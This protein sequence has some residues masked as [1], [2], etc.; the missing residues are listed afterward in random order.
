MAD[1]VIKTNEIEVKETEKEPSLENLKNFLG[2][3]F[4]DGMSLADIDS[5]LKGKKLKILIMKVKKIY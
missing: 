2:D 5:F 3:N 1:E 4:K